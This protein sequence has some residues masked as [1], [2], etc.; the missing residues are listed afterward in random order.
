MLDEI[1]RT[2][3]G[4][5]IFYLEAIQRIASRCT[6]IRYFE[7]NASLWADIDFHPDL[8]LI[9]ENM[10]RMESLRLLDSRGPA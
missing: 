8:E 3:E 1:V 4:K 2:P 5:Q 10:V 7:F 6:S 9:R